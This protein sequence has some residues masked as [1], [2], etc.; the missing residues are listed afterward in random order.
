[1]GNSHANLFQGVPGLAE[2]EGVVGLRV[3]DV[4]IGRPDEWG[5]DPGRAGVMSGF[6]EVRVQSDLRLL[7]AVAKPGAL[8][9]L[10]T[11][12]RHVGSFTF[13]DFDGQLYL[14]HRS[15]DGSL[16]YSLIHHEGEQVFIERPGWP[17]I[18]QRRLWNL[19]D[20]VVALSAHGLKYHVL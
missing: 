1:M 4:P 18:H 9:D 19:A 16:V 3:E 20:L 10:P 13:K 12:L 6:R 14:V 17:W 2:L 7:A 11:C 15:N 5:L 8:P